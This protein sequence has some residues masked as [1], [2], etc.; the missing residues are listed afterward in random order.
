[1]LAFFSSIFHVMAVCVWAKLPD[2][3]KRWWW[4]WHAHENHRKQETALMPVFWSTVS[5]D[6]VGDLVFECRNVNNTS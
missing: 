2:L 4:W 6:T 3:N 5:T 1:M